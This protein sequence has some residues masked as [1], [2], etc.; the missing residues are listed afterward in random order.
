[1]DEELKGYI[2]QMIGS[3]KT[4]DEVMNGLREKGVDV[5]ITEVVRTLY[6]VGMSG[7]NYGKPDMSDPVSIF[8]WLVKLQFERVEKMRVLEKETPLLLA[9]M[10]NN[11]K[12]LAD[13]VVK[14]QSLKGLGDVDYK[15]RLEQIFFGGS[16]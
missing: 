6:E 10:T 5:P 9:E 14:R 11:I 4:L 12:L 7:D 15:T 1:M 2:I 3:G 8:D 16:E 13:L